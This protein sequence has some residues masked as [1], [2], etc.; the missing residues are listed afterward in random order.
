MRR[1]IWALGLVV[2]IGLAGAVY[3]LK[4]VAGPERDLTLT[5]DAERGAYFVRLGGCVACHTDLKN[6]GPEL[7][8]GA[9]LKTAFGDFIPPNITPDPD[10]GIGK[11]TLAEF[12]DAMS[13]GKGPG[14][15]NHYYPA[16][17]Y[18]NYTLFSDQDIVD[19]YAGLMAKEPVATPAPA[20]RVSFPFNIRLGML[21][22][23]NLF[24]TP[25]RFEPDPAKSEIWNRGAYLANGPAHCSACHTPR[26]LLGARDDGRALEGG[27]GTPGGNVPGI[28]K[29]RLLREGYDR[30]S[31][32][33]ALKTGFTPGFDVL[34]GPMGEVIEESTVHWADEDLEALAVYRL[35]ES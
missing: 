29:A 12:S 22:W 9:A 23:K 19:L 27:S 20:H 1:F 24:F 25:E 11:W 5:A 30:A 15:F 7:A 8:G 10:A 4:P 14:L 28:S 6:K 31:L 17:P 32:V 13:N 35:D 26:N 18:D 34:G 2:V 33:E 3:L 21:V 16:F